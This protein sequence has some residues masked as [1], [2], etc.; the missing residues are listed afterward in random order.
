MIRSIL[1]GF[2]YFFSFLYAMEV[3]NKKE[4]SLEKYFD[5]S[6]LRNDLS[7]KEK[8]YIK[9]IKTI[10]VCEDATWSSFSKSK[11]DKESFTNDFIK[12]ILK[13]S[14][15]K[16][17][18][19]FTDSWEESL[20]HIKNKKCDIIAVIN[21]TQKRSEY[22]NFTKPYISYPLMIVTHK[23]IPYIHNLER[24]K[25]K[26]VAISSAY[27]GIKPIL[28]KKYKG[29]EFIY[30]E[31]GLS[32][33]KKVRKKEIFA[34]IDLLPSLLSIF[35]EVK[36]I[37]INREIDVKMNLSVGIRDDDLYL[38]SIITKS[39]NSLD[40]I[41]KNKIFNKLIDLAYKKRFDLSIIYEILIVGFVL[42][43]IVIYWNIRLKKAV[44][45]ATLK[46]KE[47]ERLL[48]YYSKQDAMKDLVGNISHQWRQPIDELSSNLMYIEAKQ[49]LN[50]EI[51]QDEIKVRAQKSRDIINFLSN[52]IST[53]RFF[54]ETKNENDYT[55][56]YELLEKTLFIIQGSFT[57]SNIKVNFEDINPNIKIKGYELQQVFLSIFNNIKNIV[58]ERNISDPIIDIKLYKSNNKIVIE[59][60]DNCGGVE[61]SV[62]DIFDLGNTN[63]KNGTGLGLYIS[64][65]IIEDKY[66]GRIFAKNIEN[67]VLFKIL[68]PIE[69]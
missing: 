11:R 6:S 69:S 61:N 30:V 63:T 58:L 13:K 28:E 18:L 56:I 41:E 27:E 26:K 21:K 59:I 35:H 52:T 51:S 7:L 25:G 43:V 55:C 34:Y 60:K 8:E 31:D 2:L 14:D 65:R 57:Q 17:R 33:L 49:L 44:K 45:E 50:K 40:D 54:Y 37:K 22:I 20:E 10:N 48:Y 36:W 38:Y 64:K 4:I 66:K 19:I 46:V 15:L 1:I 42:G 32:A 29:L 67:G 53:F 62:M 47:K 39:L 9:K 16:E 24:L 12:E 5:N 3:D 23:T 68:I